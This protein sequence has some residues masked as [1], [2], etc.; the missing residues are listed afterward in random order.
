[1]FEVKPLRSIF[2]NISIK[3][4]A[5]FDHQ[6]R[7]VNKNKWTVF[8]QAMPLLIFTAKNPIL[9]I[10]AD[11]Y[12][13]DRIKGKFCSEQNRKF[14]LLMSL[15]SV[16]WSAPLMFLSII[17]LTFKI[18]Y[19]KTPQ[20]EPTT[21]AGCTKN[22]SVPIVFILSVDLQNSKYPDWIYQP[23]VAEK[24]KCLLCWGNFIFLCKLGSR[25]AVF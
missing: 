1:M 20:Q 4:I 18:N 10:K 14:S 17:H 23:F 12:D 11:A 19:Q 25:R 13:I 3:I 15:S 7:K 16:F 2:L 21:T 8:F 22:L 9:Q 24:N 5:S 6:I